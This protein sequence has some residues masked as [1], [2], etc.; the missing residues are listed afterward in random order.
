[1]SILLT[2]SPPLEL[3]THNPTMLVTEYDHCF[4]YVK[5]SVRFL[6]IAMFVYLP[7]GFAHEGKGESRG[8]K[9]YINE[10]RFNPFKW[11][12]FLQSFPWKS[13]RRNNEGYYFIHLEI[14]FNVRRK[15]LQQYQKPLCASVSVRRFKC[16]STFRKLSTTD[17]DPFYREIFYSEMIFYWTDAK[18][19]WCL[20][21]WGEVSLKQ[22]EWEYIWCCRQFRAP[23]QAGASGPGEGVPPVRSSNLRILSELNF[24]FSFFFLVINND[25]MIFVLIVVRIN[26]SDIVFDLSKVNVPLLATLSIGLQKAESTS[27]AFPFNVFVLFQSESINL[28]PAGPWLN[29]GSVT[30]VLV[31]FKTTCT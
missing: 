28:S 15:Q 20:R 5:I 12:S 19:H 16:G 4:S 21:L 26:V 3:S 29:C 27:V 23:G 8:G 1:M 18:S 25:L 10:K 11:N 2:S 24:S 22:F 14:E 17:S 13:E 31:I 9:E 6:L 7:T 30:R